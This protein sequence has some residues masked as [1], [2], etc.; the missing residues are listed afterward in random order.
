MLTLILKLILGYHCFAG[1]DASRALA[2]MSFSDEDITN[3]DLSDLTSSQRA[4]L[5]EWYF[6]FKYIKKYPIVGRLSSPS[7]DLKLS[8]SELHKYKDVQEI[9]NGRVNAPLYFGINGKIIDASYGGLEF[10]GVDGPY[11]CLVG[12][13]ASRALAKMSITEEDLLSSD[14]SDLSADQVQ[15]LNDWYHRLTS[16]YPIVGELI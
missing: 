4:Q 8:V 1:R 5:D 3:P 6:K 2:K 16:K 7:N 15:S 11:Y 12:N 10:Y 9:P 13:D 14:L